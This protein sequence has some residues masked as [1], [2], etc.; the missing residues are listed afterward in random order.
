MAYNRFGATDPNQGARGQRRDRGDT[1]ADRHYQ[2]ESEYR[3]FNRGFDDEDPDQGIAFKDSFEQN[4]RRRTG[5]YGENL[6]EDEMKFNYRPSTAYGSF[7]SEFD[8]TRGPAAFR[9]RGPK[10]YKRSDARI[11]EDVCDRLA[12]DAHIDASDI[13]VDVKDSIVT[14]SGSI[15]CRRNK[16][17]AER[18]IENISGV[19]DVRNHLSLKENTSS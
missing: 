1:R 3:N 19:K 4:E 6:E 7:Y 8:M 11:K 10:G 2:K 17:H 9:G 14:L 16:R 5:R 18:I 12:Y 15:D 13:E